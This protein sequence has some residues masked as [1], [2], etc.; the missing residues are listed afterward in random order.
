VAS[1]PGTTAITAALS[2][3]SA[4]AALTTSLS[5]LFCPYYPRPFFSSP[6]RIPIS[7]LAVLFSPLFFFSSPLHP[8]TIPALPQDELSARFC[9]FLLVS[10]CKR[11]LI[12]HALFDL[13]TSNQRT[14]AFA[15]FYRFEACSLSPFHRDTRHSFTQLLFSRALQTFSSFEVIRLNCRYLLTA[16]AQLRSNIST[17]VASLFYIYSSRVTHKTT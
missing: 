13:C 11:D 2:P 9:F 5:V 10:P 1:G 17:S 12:P 6:S 4:A 15:D 16:I 8:L 3:C 7:A 14:N